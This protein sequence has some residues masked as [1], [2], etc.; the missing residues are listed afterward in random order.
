MP[1]FNITPIQTTLVG[2][3]QGCHHCSSSLHDW[4]KITQ[5]LKTSRPFYGRDCRLE[6]H[7]TT[8]EDFSTI[9]E[10]DESCSTSEKEMLFPQPER[11]K[12]IVVAK[13]AE[14]VYDEYHYYHPGY[15]YVTGFT[16][17]SIGY[18]HPSTPT[19]V[20]GY[21]IMPKRMQQCVGYSSLISSTLMEDENTTLTTIRFLRISLPDKQMF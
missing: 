21:E 14:F 2:G 18:V 16:Q 13:Q 19:Y 6:N 10:I 15:G 3:E 9:N 17:Q 20:G 4:S 5:C 1:V 7:G 11:D 8:C 12:Y